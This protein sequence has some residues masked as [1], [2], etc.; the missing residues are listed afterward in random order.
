MIKSTLGR[1][2]LILF[3]NSVYHEEKLGQERGRRNQSR[4]QT[5][6]ERVT[7]LLPMVFSACFFRQLGLTRA[8]VVPLTVGWAHPHQSFIKT[9]PS[10]L[11][12]GQLD[13]DILID[14]S[15]SWLS[16]AW[17]KLA[18]KQ[19]NHNCEAQP[20]QM[21]VQT[22]PSSFFCGDKAFLC[23]PRLVWTTLLH[24]AHLDNELW[25]LALLDVAVHL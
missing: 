4:V 16:L 8:G 25:I 17:V 24:G 15:S 21:S 18:N 12:T 7:G 11:P 3:Y 19:I 5:M 22:L 6:E 2:G 20:S 14:V 13:G 9:M 10:N 1:K 23:T